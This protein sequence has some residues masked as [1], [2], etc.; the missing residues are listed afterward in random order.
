MF[1]ASRRQSLL[2]GIFLILVL[3]FVTTFRMGVVRGK[4]MEPTYEDGQI[5]LVRR[6]NWFHGPL[7]HNDVVLVQQE[8]DVIIKRVYRL[9]GEEIDDNPIRVAMATRRN[10]L[11][12]YYEQKTIQTPNG[13]ETHLYVPEGYVVIIGDNLRV[14]EDSRL[15]GPVP[16]RNILGRVV[17]APPPPR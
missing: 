6:W 12:D 5:V 13:P 8:R 15:F 4:S 16:Q 1:R 3:V 2:L 11:S 7:H 14:S 17:A 10:D 9:S